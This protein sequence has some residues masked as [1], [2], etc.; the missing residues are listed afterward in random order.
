[1]FFLNNDLYSQNK[2]RF[3]VNIF[4]SVINCKTGDFSY[5]SAGAPTYYLISS[6]NILSSPVELGLS[7]ASMPNEKYSI[8]TGNL[9]N[10]NML[11]VYT[12]GVLSRQN[13][14]SE[15]YGEL[16]LKKIMSAANTMDPTMFLEKIA[17]DITLFSKGQFAQVDDYTLLAIKISD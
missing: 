12:A 7:L 1:M 4:V 2:G 5:V 13:A 17:E 15:K 14:T 16:R 8:G 11:L 9:S 3:T 10:G 6:Q